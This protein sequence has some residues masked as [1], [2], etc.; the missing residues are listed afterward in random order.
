MDRAANC[1]RLAYGFHCGGQIGF[2]SGEFFES[3]LRDFSDDIVDCRLEACRGD[4]G[5][6]IVQFVQRKAYCEL[7]RDLGDRK[8]CRL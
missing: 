6:V 7:G 1:H 2:G 5:D 4:T 8:A 3:E